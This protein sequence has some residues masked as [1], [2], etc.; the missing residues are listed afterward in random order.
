MKTLSLKNF[1]SRRDFLSLTWKTLL[2]IS[3][4]LGLG[5]IVKYLSYEP[6]PAPATK[7]DLGLAQGMPTGS[8]LTIPEANAALLP[9]AD[10]F[11]A[12]SLVCPHLGCIVELKKTEFACPCHGSKFNLDGTLKKGPAD[13]GLQTL[14]LEVDS[15][16]HLI[17]DTSNAP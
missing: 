2:G 1:V 12:V 15:N 10:G 11:E 7:F 14:A 17:L 13:R 3:G 8:I 9:T 4:L 16:G 6:Y 5:G